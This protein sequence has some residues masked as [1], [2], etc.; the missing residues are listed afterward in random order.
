MF[1]KLKKNNC[2]IKFTKLV[3]DIHIVVYADAAFGNLAGGGS[4][5]GYLSVSCRPTQQLQ[6]IQLAVKKIK[7]Y[8]WKHTFC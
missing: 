8:C 3:G 1:R 6:S 7:T 5:G 2:T 4:Q